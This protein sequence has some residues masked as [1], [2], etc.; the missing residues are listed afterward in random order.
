MAILH[1]TREC[2]QIHHRAA[3]II[4]ENGT[5]L[6]GANRGFPNHAHRLGS[7]GHMHRH[8]IRFGKQRMQAWHGLRITMGQLG[9]VIKIDHPH[10]EGFC[11]HRKLRTDIA[12]TDN[13]Q[14][15]ATDFPAIGG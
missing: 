3:R 1:R 6:H 4:H 15:L 14:R 11:Q 13:A 7:F 2:F 12:I 5:G 8:G 9:R 10:A